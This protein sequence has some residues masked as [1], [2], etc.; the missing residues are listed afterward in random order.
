MSTCVGMRSL[1][2]CL[3]RTVGVWVL[4]I[5]ERFLPTRGRELQVPV[6]RF[7][8]RVSVIPLRRV[9]LSRRLGVLSTTS[10]SGKAPMGMAVLWCPRASLTCRWGSLDKRT[11]D[12]CGAGT[13]KG[14]G[15][16][17]DSG[18]ACDASDGRQRGPAPPSPTRGTLRRSCR[19]GR[20]PVGP[21]GS[22]ACLVAAVR[23][24]RPGTWVRDAAATTAAT[25]ARRATDHRARPEA[26]SH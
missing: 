18:W 11:Q 17:R 1:L 2:V 3:I 4:G 24:A 22:G 16:T 5:Q 6:A 19:S 12:T 20:G 9:V 15:P 7:L 23:A 25:H 14:S 26:C 21:S 8:E 13:G 10:G